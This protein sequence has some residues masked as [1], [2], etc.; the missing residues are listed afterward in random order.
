MAQASRRLRR[1][2]SGRA[3]VSIRPPDGDKRGADG[4]LSSSARGYGSRWRKARETVLQRQPLCVPS[5]M[6]DGVIRAND[7]LDHLYPHCGLSWLFWE[8]RLWLPCRKRWHDSDKQAIEARGEV[9]IDDLAER[10]GYPSLAVL[11]PDR[12]DE[13]RAAFRGGV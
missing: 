2:P 3:R 10:L 11:H 9:A 1:R 8:K 6:L 4:K 7:T 5:L 12:V 13:W